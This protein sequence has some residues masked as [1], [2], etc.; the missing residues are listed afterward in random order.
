ML[1]LSLFFAFS[2]AQNDEAKIS[3][4]AQSDS[5]GFQEKYG[6]RFGID[7][8]R[9]GRTAFTDDY[10]GFEVNADYRLGK[11]LY[12]A[13]ELGFEEKATKTNFLDSSGKGNYFKVGLD[14]NLYNN[15]LGMENLIISGLRFGGASFSQTRDRYAVYDTNSQTWGQIQ[16]IERTEFSGLSTL[17][18]ELIF[19]IKAEILN[20]VFLGI[21]VQLKARL[22][23]KSPSN[24]ENIF[25]PGFGRT[26]DSS[27][28]G[29]GFNYTLSYLLPIYKKTRGNK[30]NEDLSEDVVEDQ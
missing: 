3:N 28:V 13:G 23:E 27:K 16:N 19:G 25:I 8:S 22:S 29:T 17:W 15:W 11:K 26:Y 5:I 9:L 2:F 21:N 14:Y 7:L 10:A 24:F 30:P 6:L 20:N 1:F 18:A 12:V 4:E